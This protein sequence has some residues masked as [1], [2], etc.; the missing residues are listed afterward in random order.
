MAKRINYQVLFKN[1]S[2]TSTEL[3]SILKISRHTVHY[4]VKQCGLKP[5]NPTEHCWIFDGEV[6]KAFLKAK[7]KR[8]KVK[9]KENEIYCLSC[10]LGMEVIEDSIK[11]EY[12]G[13]KVG[14]NDVEQIIIHGICVTC[15]HECRRLSSSNRIDEFLKHYPNYSK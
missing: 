6:L 10:R 11:L 5:L 12:T 3:A 13:K 15:G 4:W 7:L 8:F 2:Y 9:I 1:S 14:N